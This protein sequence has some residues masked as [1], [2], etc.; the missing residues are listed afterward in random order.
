M[1]A[2]IVVWPVTTQGRDDQRITCQQDYGPHL[3]G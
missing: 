1:H 3:Q 2:H